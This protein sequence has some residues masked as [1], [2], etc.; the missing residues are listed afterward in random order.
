MI[1]NKYKSMK[2]ITITLLMLVSI[3][4]YSQSKQDTT[5]KNRLI[6]LENQVGDIE[7]INLEVEIATLKDKLDFQQKMSEQSISSISNQLDSAS[8][9]L[10]L[11]G[12]LFGIGAIGLGLYVTYIERKI[13]KIG[14]ENKELLTKNQKIKED[15]E[16]LNR[17]I[18]S[19]IY[20]LFLKIKREESV[21]ILDRLVKVPKDISNVCQ[22]LLS[23]ELERED[24]TK[25]RQAYSNLGDIKNEYHHQ[26]HL[27]FFQHFLDL[28][29]KDDK[30]RKDISEFIPTG[31][32]AAFENDIIKST[33]DFVTTLVDLGIQEF[34]TEVNL[35]FK[36][37]TNSE[38]KTFETVYQLLFDNL[39]S[40]KN[41]FELF[42]VIESSDDKRQAKIEFGKL[43]KNKYS[44][45]NPTESENLTFSELTELIAAQQKAEEEAKQKAEEQKKQQEERKKEQEV[46]KKLQEERKKQLAEQNKNK[47]D[48]KP[49]R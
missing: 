23:R 10:T 48:E 29:L 21:H 8:Y 35:F 2:I 43:L 42:S 16:T 39:K 13:V 47:S 30:L 41:R 28:S 34:K 44:V 15:V 9:N 19:D 45:D 18:Q 32:S 26:Y 22:T 46:R 1:M 12:L 27:L 5:W 31:I 24:F 11:F 7:K 37:L 33:F 6:K 40:R 38:F 36:G 25:L 49:S 14:E 4:S 3:L 20:N 17:L